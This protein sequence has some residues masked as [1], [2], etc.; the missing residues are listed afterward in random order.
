MNPPRRLPETAAK[1]GRWRAFGVWRDVDSLL[2][3]HLYFFSGC[4][5]LLGAAA[6]IV[7]APTDAVAGARSIPW[8]LPAGLLLVALGFHAFAYVLNDVV[9]LAIDRHNPWRGHDPMVRGALGR[10]TALAIAAAAALASMPLAHALGGLRALL[11]LVAG[12]ACIVVYD[13]YGKR[14]R[15]PPLTD[16]VQG[17]AWACLVLVG[18]AAASR[19]EAPISTAGAGL[20][21]R[22]DVLNSAATALTPV[23]SGAPELFT[24]IQGAFSAVTWIA[25]AHSGLF[26]LALNG[27]HGGLRDL[28]SD[29]A[30]GART[31]AVVLGARLDADGRLHVTWPLRAFAA[32]ATLAVVGIVTVPLLSGTFGDLGASHRISSAVIVL[33]DAGI[34]ALLAAIMKPAERAWSAMAR[35]HIVLMFALLPVALWAGMPWPLRLGVLVAGGVSAAAL[36]ASDVWFRTSPDSP[37]YGGALR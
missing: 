28:G 35:L 19:G 30:H 12:C 18:A 33:M 7:S 2:R 3:L 36:I 13:V 23:A 9:D 31:T 20:A 27:V 17:L 8:T 16:A 10:G 29:L 11:A 24:T 5:P 32:A 37:N 21:G 34:I 15:V 22:V 26:V 6:A 4:L 1:A 14:T 25:F